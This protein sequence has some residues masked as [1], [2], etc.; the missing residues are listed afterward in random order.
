MDT[1]DVSLQPSQESPEVI[2]QLGLILIIAAVAIGRL[3]V[4]FGPELMAGVN[5]PYY[6]VQI[7]SILTTGKLGFPDLPLVFYIQAFFAKLIGYLRFCDFSGCIMSSWK[8]IDAALYPLIAIPFFLL[9]KSIAKDIKTPKWVLL[10]P[11]ILGVASFPAWVMLGE[12]QKN[13]I[14]L[15]WSTFYIFFLYKALYGSQ[16]IDYIL[17]GLFFVLTGFTHIG[18]LGFVLAFTASFLLFSIILKRE[19]RDSLIKMSM[20]L[21]LAI[22]S[23]FAFLFFFD[24]ER[25]ERLASVIVLPMKMFEQ[26]IILNLFKDPGAT[27]LFYF[28]NPMG[29]NAN[30]IAILGII[31]FFAKR[32]EIN[33]KEKILL[34]AALS[35]TLFMGSPFLGTEWAQRLYLMAYIPTIIV[36]IFL[37]KYTAAIWKKLILTALMLFVTSAPTPMMLISGMKNTPSINRQAYNHLLELKKVIDNPEET[38]VI[39]RHG[40]EWWSAW[41]LE[42]DVS[43]KQDLDREILESYDAVFLLRQK[44]GKGQVGPPGPADQ[45]PEVEIPPGAEIIHEDKYFILARIS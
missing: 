22:T 11:S 32:Q 35:V 42:V 17:A 5:T 43:S 40:L 38:L 31:L 13:A 14:G 36:F 34:L 41:V 45:F 28:M 1:P 19:Q 44:A 33:L 7:R 9:A 3:Y 24:P 23:I 6:P 30:L 10:L 27:L 26:P 15:L 4:N 12:L 2:E 39:A 16:I 25:F 37:L 8:I 20:L 29:I 18:A 21:L